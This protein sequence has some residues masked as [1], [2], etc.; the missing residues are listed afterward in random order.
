VRSTTFL[1]TTWCTSIQFSGVTRV[2]TGAQDNSRPAAPRIGPPTT[3]GFRAP[4]RAFPRH[5]TF[6]RRTHPTTPQSTPPA[7]C[8]PPTAPVVARRSIAGVAP[9]RRTTASSSSRSRAA[10]WP[11]LFKVALLPHSRTSAESSS[12]IPPRST[13]DATAGYLPVPSSAVDRPHGR[14]F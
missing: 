1:F 4:V 3:L 5:R 14:P 8:S 9:M 2:Q 13:M 6:P 10:S 7:T 11:C 12:P